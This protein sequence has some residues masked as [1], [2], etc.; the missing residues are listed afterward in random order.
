MNPLLL[1]AEVSRLIE[2][3]CKPVRPTMLSDIVS[4]WTVAISNSTSTL[5]PNHFTSRQ[6][7]AA[8]CQKEEVDRFGLGALGSSAVFVRSV[9]VRF[10]SLQTLEH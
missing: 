4:N 3:C 9:S 10:P 8:R 2:T 7:K 1:K 6:C 5:S